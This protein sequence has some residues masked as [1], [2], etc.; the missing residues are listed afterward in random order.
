ME[1]ITAV[2]AQDGSGDEELCIVLS[3]VRD[4]NPNGT[5]RGSSRK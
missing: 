4:P 5:V 1:S 3:T 2:N